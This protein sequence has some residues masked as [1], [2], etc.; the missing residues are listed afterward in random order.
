MNEL[1]APNIVVA[2][3]EPAHRTFLPAGF[4]LFFERI[5]LALERER[6]QLPLWFVAAMGMGI[7]GWFALPGPQAWI[8]LVCVGA[9]LAAAG[10]MLPGS[11]SGKS[12]AGFGLAL[13]A[14][15]ALVWWR[16]DSL[17]TPRLA[18]PV[19]AELTG[20]VAAVETMVAKGD[21]RLTVDTATVSLPPRVRFSL[22]MED[23]PQG[24]AKGAV[25]NARVRLQ[26][27]PPM[28]L[29]GTHDFAK[30]AWFKGL[31]GVGRAIGP[32][33]VITPQAPYGVDRVRTRL[34]E[35]IRKQLPGLSGGI[36]TALA[37]GDQHAVNEADAEAMR[38]SGL[39]HLL[40][41]SGLHIA[42]V[43]GA[44]ML[45]A[46]KLLAMSERLALR[47]NLVLVA[48]GVGALA[49]VGYTLLTG[50][51]VPTVRSCIAA[52]LVLGGIALG[53]D[54]L[55]LRLVAVGALL[56]M[57]FRPEAVAG[58]SFQLSFAAVTAIIAFHSLPWTK[59]RFGPVDGGVAIRIG[60]GLLSLLATGLV[61]EVALIPF[62]LYH[63]HKAGLYGVAANM[64]AIPWTTFVIMPAEAAA[65]LLDTVGLGAWMWAVAGWTIDVLL[66]LA[67][68]VGS[69]EGAVA[70]LPSMAR[71]AFA[72][73]VMGGLWLCLWQGQLRLAGLAPMGIGA[74]WA[75][76]TPSPDLLVTGDGRHLAIVADGKPVILRERS[77]DFVRDL[78]GEAAGHDG[79]VLELASQRFAQCN[80]DSC[81]ARIERGGRAW[82][83]LAIKS[84]DRIR[85]EVLTGACAQA[86]IV[87]APRRL[88]RACT[89]RWLKLDRAMLEQTGGVAIRLGERPI[90]ETVATRIGDHPWAS[91]PSSLHTA[92]S[93]PDGSMKWKR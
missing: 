78:L 60:R 62:A 38:R 65:L 14:G 5:E 42:A 68:T 91:A 16:A 61:V 47:F 43:V 39:T 18:R 52:L 55:S 46:L 71:G 13:A 58:A 29:P 85:W 4:A 53:R 21:F 28:A 6:A 27:P 56:V 67:R 20:T 7:A 84:S 81:V 63:F 74:I 1:S 86:D 73:I 83:L 70:S 8:G 36:A 32:V 15:C 90:V 2:P 77:G 57:L 87:V 93:L 69:A 88:P 24:L 17:A 12:L 80:R 49:G 26:P 76:A 3:L 82:T 79:D 64:F 45:L 72:M 25:V 35:H 37:T 33:A 40:S 51:Q 66:G 54:A 44:A 75:L 23:A 41:V 48:A 22:P 59:R 31:G 89:P 34:D 92:S 30:D 10:L 50:M 9:A 11:W 19:I